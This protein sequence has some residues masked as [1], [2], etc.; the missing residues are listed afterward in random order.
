MR[1]QATIPIQ[2]A[3]VLG[4]VQKFLESVG[5][6]SKQSKRVYG[7]A[8][9]HFQDFLQVNYSPSNIESILDL[10]IMEVSTSIPY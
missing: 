8:V 6:N 1:R 4:K 9:A 2:Q 10:L 7:I 5:R 3:C